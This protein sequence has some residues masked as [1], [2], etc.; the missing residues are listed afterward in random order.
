MGASGLATGVHV[1]FE[2]RQGVSWA[3]RV[4]PAPFMD[5]HVCGY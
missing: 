3:G 2:V 1:H 4:N 5:V